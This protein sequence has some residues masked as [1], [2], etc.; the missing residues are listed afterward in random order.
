MQAGND[1]VTGLLNLGRFRA[2]LDVEVKRT[3]RHGRP[4]CAAVL[5]IDA[6]RAVNADHG[7]AVG[8]ELLT[9]AGR[10]LGAGMR[11]HDLACR[12][13]ADEFAILLPETDLAGAVTTMQR[14]LAELENTTVG[15]VESIRG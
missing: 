8:D 1:P 13:G 10:A 2:Q 11:A 6:F 12:T 9:A 15:P 5:D 7:Y 3:R 4:L 14:V